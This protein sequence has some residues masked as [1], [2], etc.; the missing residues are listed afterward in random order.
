MF[1]YKKHLPIKELVIR[2]QAKE[3]YRLTLRIILEE[4]KILFVKKEVKCV[5]LNH[6]F[7]YII[8]L[9]VKLSLLKD[10]KTRQRNCASPLIERK[11]VNVTNWIH[12]NINVFHE[13]NLKRKT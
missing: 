13:Q 2:K 11:K 10:S 3:L 4:M 6:F 8:I 7:Q 9:V 5:Y 1:F 12:T